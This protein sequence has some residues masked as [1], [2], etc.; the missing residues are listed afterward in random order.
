MQISLKNTGLLLNYNGLL[1]NYNA[2]FPKKWKSGLI[3][4]LL[5]RAKLICSD[6]FLFFNIVG[7]LGNMFAS[8]GYP[9]WF[10]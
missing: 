9:L 1:L 4:C 3:L 10:F 2:N 6:S 7:V 8:D 5:Y